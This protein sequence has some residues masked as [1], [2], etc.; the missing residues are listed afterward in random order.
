MPDRACP[1]ALWSRF[2]SFSLRLD[3]S[4]PVKNGC[5]MYCTLFLLDYQ[6]LRSVV[7]LDNV[8]ASWQAISAGGG[9]PNF[10]EDSEKE[11]DTLECNC[12][13]ARTSS[14]CPRVC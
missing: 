2:F 10:R 8:R 12:R 5:Y 9:V 13:F 1:V 7:K 14:C 11:Q 4:W 3:L 6:T